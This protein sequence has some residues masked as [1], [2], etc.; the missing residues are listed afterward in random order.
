MSHLSDQVCDGVADCDGGEDESSS[1]CSDRRGRKLS[2][3]HDN[4]FHD[5]DSASEETGGFLTEKNLLIF[6]AT[7]TV[8][9]AVLASLTIIIYN[10]KLRKGA[11]KDFISIELSKNQH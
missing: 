7:L 2:L 4:L 10:R 5:K 9:L 11:S 3:D 6:G 8:S 1:I